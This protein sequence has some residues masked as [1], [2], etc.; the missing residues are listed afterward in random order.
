VE[1][2]FHL[3]AAS[4]D[5][6]ARGQFQLWVSGVPSPTNS[7]VG[8]FA[9]LLPETGQKRLAD[10]YTVDGDA[11]AAQLSFPPRREH[12]ENITRTPR[13]LP[14]VISL[15]EHH[16]NDHVI[17]LD[18]LAITADTTQLHLARIST[19]QRVE[20]HVPHALEMTVQTPPLARFLAEVT[21][22]RSGV[23]A[24]FDFGAAQ[25]MP[26]RPRV[27]CG[28]SILA[29]ARWTLSAQVLPGPQSSVSAWEYAFNAW[30]ERWQAPSA[31]VLCEGERRLP[32]ELD[33]QLDAALLRDRL[34]RSGK[35]EL[36]E[37][38]SPSTWA[39]RPCELLV[40]LRSK[41]SAATSVRH[42]APR[43]DRLMPGTSA[44]LQAEL[45]GH[46][47][48]YDE[49]LTQELP[50]LLNDI[51]NHLALWWFRRHHDST[52]PDSEQHLVLCLRL[53]QTQL[54]GLVAARLA[55]WAG[56]VRARGLLA[57]LNL[58]AHRPQHHEYGAAGQG[59][60]EK[61]FA[62]DSTA[63][64][65]Q[66]KLATDTSISQQAIAAASL[67][68]I[69]ASLTA[70]PES[71]Y[72]LLLSLLPQEHGKLDRSLREAALRFA[73]GRP[74]CEPWTRRRET[75]AVLRDQTTQDTERT[76]VLR[77]LLHD[78]HVR[79][80]GIDPGVERVTNRLARA[81]AQRRIALIRRSRS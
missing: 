3:S 65:A 70:S 55:D 69:A 24:P 80:V 37:V 28:R 39:G 45:L 6:L 51:E 25:E 75:L 31:A 40:A 26:Y 68:D 41:N 48:R 16:S 21:T 36:R 23:Y 15:S 66:I 33:N 10:T 14:H 73:T 44:M 12:N 43:A 78:H 38:P 62:A 32:L 19:G 4:T 13:L 67:A 35:A 71:G 52:R 60:I 30:R 61:V 22:A 20:A 54:Y 1:L 2:A 8:R 46:P 18:D 42:T 7:M 76:A 56:Y 9:H 63:A 58:T 57:D 27:R 5:A 34:N 47:L 53:H 79:A 17:G 50:E 72:R 11:V 81:V 74:D 29:P 59:D 49:I 77:A 64:I